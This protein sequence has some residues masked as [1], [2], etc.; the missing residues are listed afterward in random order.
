[1]F[2]EIF[3]QYTRRL[4]DASALDFDD[5]IAR[6]GATC[7]ARSPRSRRSTSGRFRHILVDEYQDTNHAQYALIRELTQPVP[8]AG[9]SRWST[10]GDTG[11]A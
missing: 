6:D 5:L 7:S 1:M 10:H 2:L 3:R 8:A 4:R 9:W 11:S